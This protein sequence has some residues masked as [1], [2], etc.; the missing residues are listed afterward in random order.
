MKSM[1][2]YGKVSHPSPLGSIEIE[3]KSFNH[4]FLN[5][6]YRA[7]QI[8]AAQEVAVTQY[9]KKKIARG[10]LKISVNFYPAREASITQLILNEDL[11]RQYYEALSRLSEH[12]S[13]PSS[14]RTGDFLQCPEIFSLEEKENP[15]LNSQLFEALEKCL[16]IFE[17]YR[18][19]EGKELQNHLENITQKMEDLVNRLEEEAQDLL[20]QTLEKFRERLKEF[21]SEVPQVPEERLVQEAVFWCN[22]ADITE[23][24]ERLRAHLKEIRSTC[25]EKGPTGRKLDFTAQECSR[26]INTISS[27]SNRYSLVKIALQLKSEAEKMREQI[28]NIE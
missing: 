17:Q 23:E 4:R 26:E 5:I 22:K 7:N 11:A 13:L 2:G 28:Q 12:F 25:K 16:E 3:I 9:L 18:E 19:R 24:I 10:S 27:K 20:P 15:E 14:L 6:R 21:S 8:F 1:T